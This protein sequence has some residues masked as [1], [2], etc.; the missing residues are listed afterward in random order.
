MRGCASR[1]FL[2]GIA[3]VAALAIAATLD[4]STRL[5]D[6]VPV[7]FQLEGR[8]IR[9][10]VQAWDLLG[11]DG[12]FGR[13][14]WKRLDAGEAWHVHAAIIDPN[15]AEHW[16]NVGRVLSQIEGGQVYA[17]RALRWASW[18][19]KYT[20]AVADHLASELPPTPE[21]FVPPRPHV[22][23]NDDGPFEPWPEMSEKEQA[24][25]VALLKREME[26][27]IAALKLTMLLYEQ[28]YVLVYSDLPQ[29]EAR[30]KLV[31]L[32]A[33]YLTLLQSFRLPPDHNIFWGKLVVI[34]CKE[35]AT[36][37]RIK[38]ELF[39]SGASPPG[40]AGNFIPRGPRG[41]LVM[42]NYPDEMKFAATV[43]HEFTHAFMHRY[44]SP[45]RLPL[46]LDEGFA[47]Y[48]ASLVLEDSPVDKERRS[49]GEWFIQHGGPIENIM[50]MS[51]M[52]EGWPGPY[53]AAYGVSYLLVKEMFRENPSK[54][55]GCLTAVKDGKPW[56][57]AL[58][59]DLGLTREQLVERLTKRVRSNRSE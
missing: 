57:R 30:S 28:P 49:R 15:I 27:A 22:H 53:T 36:F 21:G 33:T 47:D 19:A 56:E 12:T 38:R 34:I 8:S 20:A 31:G 48:I 9:G 24:E 3:A 11:F 35:Q 17:E 5:A 39:S 23:R 6:P 54:A 1:T 51:C 25:A 46:W 44:R 50:D 41:Y 37:D 45:A 43:P 2:R 16:L 59:E 55:L 42:W 26:E 40:M 7:A 10:H 4:A 29:E 18:L 13:I 32:R 52:H 14:E 58:A